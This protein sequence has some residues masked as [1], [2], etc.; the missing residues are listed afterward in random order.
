MFLG[1]GWA[2]GLPSQSDAEA[3]FRS[4]LATPYLSYLTQYDGIRRA[5][6]VATATG[7][8]SVGKLA[9]D[10]RGY[11]PQVQ[12]ISDQDITDALAAEADAHPRPAGEETL[13]MAIISHQT[14]PVLSDHPDAGG[15]HI[16]FAHAGRTY[17]YGVVLNWSGNT[18]ANIWESSGSLPATFAHEVVEAC[19]DP[20][21]S[22]GYRLTPSQNAAD[23]GENE[24]S[25]FAGQAVLR[26]PGMTRDVQLEG[27]WSN[28]HNTWV[29]PTGYS[30]R[31][32]LRQQTPQ[33]VPNV[34]VA[35]GAGSVRSA[36]RALCS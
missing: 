33:H 8:G 1:D 20:D 22:T 6:I 19:T 30:L 17:A 36:V 32:A 25:D 35:L 27:Y 7:P 29:V 3:C 5:E 15:F 24:L 34:K 21:G 23:A 11:L 26:L 4:L 16:Q 28:V 12:L 14:L 31:A 10:P 13:Y 9:P 18:A 2:A